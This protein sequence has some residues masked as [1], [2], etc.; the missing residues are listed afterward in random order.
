MK[1]S[2][3][4]II[5]AI[6]AGT[7]GALGYYIGCYEPKWQPVSQYDLENNAKDRAN[8]MIQ[9]GSPKSFD[10]LFEDVLKNYQSRNVPPMMD[11]PKIW[12]LFGA[13]TF[14][15]AAFV[16]AGMHMKTKET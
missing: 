4:L 11:P 16:I 3:R 10:E 7:G 13:L 8:K 5:S 2:N 1:Q 9:E 15:G 12:A 14:G 6:S